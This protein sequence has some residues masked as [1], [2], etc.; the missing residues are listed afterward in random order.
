MP[1]RSIMNMRT[2]VLDEG[3]AAVVVASTWLMGMR[4]DAWL[5]RARTCGFFPPRRSYFLFFSYFLFLFKFTF[6]LPQF[7][8]SLIFFLNS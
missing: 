7:F 3:E 5:R 4:A 6:P 8:K 1:D 2:Y